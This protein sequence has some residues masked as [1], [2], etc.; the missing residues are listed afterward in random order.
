MLLL[1]RLHNHI[2]TYFQW[3][4]E[5]GSRVLWWQNI[6]AD[7]KVLLRDFA[8][9]H[10]K[11]YQHWSLIFLVRYLTK[12]SKSPWLNQVSFKTFLGSTWRTSLANDQHH[13]FLDMWSISCTVRASQCCTN[14]H[15]YYNLYWKTNRISIQPSKFRSFIFWHETDETTVRFSNLHWQY[16]GKNL[17][18]NF[19]E[20]LPIALEFNSI[21][22]R[23]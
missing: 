22:R 12:I 4:I 5:P 16:H 9:N 18:E 14:W 3:T 6:K 7:V 1:H 2:F 21:L 10:D 15:N 19:K 8:T 17:E 11:C 20:T 23:E 13:L